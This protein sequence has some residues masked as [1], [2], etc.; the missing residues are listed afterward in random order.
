MNETFYIA[1]LFFVVGALF[2]G[3][4]IPLMLGRIRPNIWYGFRTRKTLS[5]D[6]IWYSINQVTGKDMM[7]VGAILTV[8]SLVVMAMQDRISTESAVLIL[9]A[10]CFAATAY[11]AFHGIAI[12]RRM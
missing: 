8:V 12:L 9:V 3:L 6:E 2:V 10:V 5:N 1:L 7:W 4:G 11:M